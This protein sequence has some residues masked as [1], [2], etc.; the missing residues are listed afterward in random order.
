MSTTGRDRTLAALRG[1][2]LDGYPVWLMRQAGR[3]LPEYREL[4]TR[5]SFLEL[6]HSAEACTEAALQPLRRFELDATIVFSDILT[7]PDALGAGL[8]FEKGDGPTFANPVRTEA[9]LDALQWEGVRERLSYVYDAV[10]SLR[11]A[12]PNH[13]LFGFAGSP[14]TLYCYVVQGSGSND[15]AIPR[16][17]L[18]RAP[19]FAKRLLDGLAELV[20]DHLVAQAEAGADAVQVFDTWGGLLPT[21]TYR[22]FVAPGLRHIVSRVGDTPVILYVKAGSHLV[23]VTST[24]GFTAL[25]VAETVD[26]ADVRARGVRTQ[27]NLDPTVLHADRSV[28]REHTHRIHAAL[29]GKRD[30]VFNLGHGIVPSTPPEGVAA[31]VE[32]VRDL[33]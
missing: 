10:R 9:D 17:L 32:A 14:W 29:R 23:D 6:I 3:F 19:A 24:L 7:I 26:L 15:F 20:A 18:F 2:P 13:A 12:A 1:D 21:E 30:H 33:G 11:A 16:S 4:R 8:K 25:S 27:G 22:T 31:F 5:L 28:I